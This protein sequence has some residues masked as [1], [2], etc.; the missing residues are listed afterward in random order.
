MSFTISPAFIGCLISE[1]LTFF[2][3][4]TVS[5]GKEIAAA[6]IVCAAEAEGLLAQAER[7]KVSIN[8]DCVEIISLTFLAQQRCYIL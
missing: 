4:A 1:A 8:T 3:F 7:V 2:Y 6:T 5:D